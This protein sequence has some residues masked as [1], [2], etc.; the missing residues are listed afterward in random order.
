MKQTL[1]RRERKKRDLKKNIFKK[2]IYLFRTQGFDQTNIEEITD[3]VDV[4][5]ATFFNYYSSK[6]EVLHELAQQIVQ[7]YKGLLEEK[8]SSDMNTADALCGVMDQVIK[9]LGGYKNLFKSVFLEMMRS[10]IGFFEDEQE[11]GQ[12]TINDVMSRV[13]RRGQERGELR[14]EDPKLLAEMLAGISTNII[15][16]WL[17]AKEPYSVEDQLK[18]AIRIFIKGA[19]VRRP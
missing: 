12:Q 8:L 5:R 9:N 1:S 3:A 15:L 18:Q 7:Y 16:N 14:N 11:D 17:N 6:H 2:A 19:E 10:Q 13:I 4:S